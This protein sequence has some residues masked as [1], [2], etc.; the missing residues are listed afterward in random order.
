MHECFHSNSPVPF[1]QLS[2]IFFMIMQLLACVVVPV[3]PSFHLVQCAQRG[4]YPSPTLC[5]AWGVSAQSLRITH[6]VMD[7]RRPFLGCFPSGHFLPP[8]GL[9]VFGRAPGFGT[10]SH[11]WLSFV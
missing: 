10:I 3:P 6:C 11:S 7:M 8:R 5:D 2:G 4:V 1:L 9:S